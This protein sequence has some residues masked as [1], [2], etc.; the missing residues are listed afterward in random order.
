MAVA[1]RAMVATY[2]EDPGHKDPVDIQLG[3]QSRW[4]NSEGPGASS[5]RT[6]YPVDRV[7]GI[8]ASRE[9]LVPNQTTK[10][11]PSYST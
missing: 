10:H 2:L 1:Q 7:A 5:Q 6:G 9:F 11:S 8:P 4:T 3:R